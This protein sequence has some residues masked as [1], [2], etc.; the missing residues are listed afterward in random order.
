[1]KLE[2]NYEIEILNQRQTE[3]KL[4]IKNPRT[5]I[6]SLEERCLGKPIVKIKENDKSLLGSFFP[7]TRFLQLHQDTYGFGARMHK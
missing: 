2:Y 6:K 3:I 4:E 5:Q 7:F 1:M